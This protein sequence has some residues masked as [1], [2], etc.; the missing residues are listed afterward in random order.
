M[1]WALF[2]ALGEVDFDAEIATIIQEERET[3][4][5][6]SLASIKRNLP[7]VMGIKHDFFG[8]L[9]FNYLSAHAPLH[10]IV[11]YN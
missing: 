3:R 10:Y 11:N 9:L 5:Y 6:I 2:N 1:T 7:K 8:Y 4:Q